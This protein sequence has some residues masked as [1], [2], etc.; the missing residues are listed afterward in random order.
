M[1]DCQN[2]MTCSIPICPLDKGW[3]K[4]TYIKGEP[5]CRLHKKTLEK[6][7]Y[8]P[9]VKARTEQGKKSYENWLLHKEEHLERLKKN[10]FIP[11]KLGGK[12]KR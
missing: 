8:F 7:G 4:R 1:Q 10:Q 5:V 12:K 9:Q 11:V 6:L 2:Y 3:S